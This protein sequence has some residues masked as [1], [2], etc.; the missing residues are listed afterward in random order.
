MYGQQKNQCFQYQTKNWKVAWEGKQKPSLDAQIFKRMT[1][2][3]TLHSFF[4]WREDIL[5]TNSSHM[6]DTFIYSL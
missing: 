5:T 1:D 3:N 6:T 4:S 2:I